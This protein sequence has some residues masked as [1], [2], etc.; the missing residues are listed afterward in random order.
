MCTLFHIILSLQLLLYCKVLCLVSDCIIGYNSALQGLSQAA[1]SVTIVG[2][3]ISAFI[4]SCSTD[5]YISE[6]VAQ[7]LKPKLHPTNK[8]IIMAQK[9]LNTSSPT[10]VVVDLIL[11]LNNQ[12][13]VLAYWMIYVLM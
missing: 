3:E 2:Q 12:S 10:Y 4:D 13:H 7:K 9:S 5:S 8:D 6:K 11:N 1:T